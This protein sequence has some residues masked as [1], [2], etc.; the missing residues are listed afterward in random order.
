MLDPQAKALIDLVI[1]NGIPP[2]HTSPPVE[3]RA[4]YAERR[5]FT[6]PDAPDVEQALDIQVPGPAGAIT[7]RSYRPLG[8]QS[9]EVLP[10]LVYYH[11]GGHVIGDLDTHDVLCRTLS[12]LARCAVFS[13]N[14]RLA[15]EHIFPAAADDCIAATKWVHANAASLHIDGTRIAIGGDSAGGQLAAV[16]AL[17]LKQDGAFKPVLQLLLYPVTDASCERESMRTNAQGYLLTRDS[18]D[19]FY[20][21]Y[22][23]ETWMRHD[24]RG[25]PMLAKDHSALPP[26]LVITAGYDPLRDE[27]RA[28]ADK[29]SA[30]GV[31][32]QYICFERQIHGFALMG[33]ILDEAN[34]AVKL[35]AQ[36]LRDRF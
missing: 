6:Q 27:G 25:S 10:A 29:L 15:P 19:Y 30:A 18:M 13:V 33:R 24:W 2:M 14:Y 26:A 5:F 11:G 16:V 20:G 12:N 17:A 7:L 8:I 4:F 36:A 32:T 34:T 3:A 22:M 35:C 23:P 1:A 9:S 28:Y 31:A 21:H